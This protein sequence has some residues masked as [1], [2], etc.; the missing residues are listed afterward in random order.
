MKA[1]ALNPTVLLEVTSD[2]SEE[3][4]TTEKVAFYKTIPSLREYIVVSH[5]ERRMVVHQR[6][7]SGQWSTR[8]AMA[9][10]QVA[11]PSLGAVL[12]VDEIY[13]A[14]TIT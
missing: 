8:V 13:R 5:R 7:E 3:Y 1:T 14:S 10:G 9:G 11:V 2:S 6:D 4:D 12:R